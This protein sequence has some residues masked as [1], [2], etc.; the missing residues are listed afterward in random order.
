MATTVRIVYH[1]RV[2]VRHVLMLR[3]DGCTHRV[4]LRLCTPTDKRVLVEAWAPIL[5]RGPRAWLDRGWSWVALDAPDQLAFNVDP[6]W[7][8]LADDV[9]LDAKGDLIGTL[10]TTGPISPAD[11]S[12]KTESIGD[13]DLVWVEYV[14]IAPSLRK[15]CPD[16]DRRKVLLKPVGSQLMIAA[17]RRSESVGC[18]G[19]VG[20]HAEGAVAEE[21]YEA[22]GMQRLP[23]APH[24]AGGAFPVFFGSA[25]WAQ[26]F[27]KKGQVSS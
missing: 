2:T 8:V 5:D 27:I 3:D 18:D 23:A 9:E 20:L 11:A 13:E 16:L 6:E 19:R 14:A 21:T 22:W 17:I 12:L 1:P 25:D 24:P 7:L 26:G 15:N 4:S 10:V